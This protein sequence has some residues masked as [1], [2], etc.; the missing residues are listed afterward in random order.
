MDGGAW[1]FLLDG[2][3]TRLLG[4]EL[5][6]MSEVEQLVPSP[7]QKFLGVVSRGE[8]HPSLDVLPLKELLALRGQNLTL[9]EDENAKMV[10]PIGQI[11]PYPGMNIS[12]AGWRGDAVIIEST[13]P[14]DE[15]HNKDRE[16]RTNIL[17]E[18]ENERKQRF[19]WSPAKNELKKL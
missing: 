16:A 6:S 7:D 11:D 10:K 3:G 9:G 19:L 14:L 5:V 2:T 1:W 12:I 4:R 13:L 18:W 17:D 8:G 15:M